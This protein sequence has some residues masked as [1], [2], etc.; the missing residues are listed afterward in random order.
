MGRGEGTAH[1]PRGC[2]AR[3]PGVAKQLEMLGQPA[4]VP[5]TASEA[6]GSWLRAQSHGH[7]RLPPHSHTP[8]SRSPR[9]LLPLP[10]F[11]WACAVACSTV[12]LLVTYTL[13]APFCLFLPF[14]PRS[15]CSSAVILP[16]SRLA[17]LGLQAPPTA[18]KGPKLCSIGIV[19]FCPYR[20]PSPPGSPR[21]SH[22]GFIPVP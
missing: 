17:G 13:P 19:S 11:A 21:C 1:R 4:P 14:T 8:A 15:H 18:D 20:C 5:P 10:L 2:R 9:A 3:R 12:S 16:S 6:R 7:C 22:E